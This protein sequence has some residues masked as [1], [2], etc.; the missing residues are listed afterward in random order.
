M[1]KLLHEFNNVVE[2]AQLTNDQKPEFH[3]HC[4]CKV[5]TISSKFQH[6]PS[7][8]YFDKSFTALS[9]GSCGRLEATGPLWWI[10][11][12]WPTARSVL[13]ALCVLA[14]R[15]AERWTRWPL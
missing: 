13:C 11:D 9:I 4:E 12:S 14:C 2:S 8:A 15:P 7:V 1:F 6:K 3:C 5:F 10:L